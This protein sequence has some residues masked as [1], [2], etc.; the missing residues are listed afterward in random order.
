[1]EVLNKLLRGITAK[2]NLDLHPITFAGIDSKNIQEWFKK[3]NR[4]AAQNLWDKQKHVEVI[5]LYI[6]KAASSYY[7]GLNKETKRDV[8]ALKKFLIKK[9]ILQKNN[10]PSG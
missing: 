2:P 9:F 4:T 8:D 10:M 1:M 5:L 7:R 3:F 6:N